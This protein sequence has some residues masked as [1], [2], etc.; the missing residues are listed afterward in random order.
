MPLT[1][2]T[3]PDARIRRVRV[4][5]RGAVQGVGFRPFVN[6]LAARLGL[7]GW[8][9]NDG[10]GVLLEVEGGGVSAFMAALESEA[11]PLARI[12]A[13]QAEDVSPTGEVGFVIRHSEQGG[14][15]T[16]IPPDAAVCDACLGELFDPS[17]RHYRYAFINCTHCGPRYT[18]TRALPYD[19]PQTSMAAFAMCADCAREY[20]DPL[21]RRFH[22]QPVACPACGP[23]LSMPIEDIVA[24]LKAGEIL[25][26]KGLGGFHIVCDARNE[27]AVSRLRERKN[28]EEKPLAVMVSN[29]VSAR[30]LAHIGYE[31][32]VLLTSLTRPII[33]LP[34]AE[35]HG[36]APS[37][38]PG[39][40]DV[41]VMLPYTPIHY[42][43]F[44]ETAGRPDGT[45]WLDDFQDLVLV[46]TSANP[47]GEPLVIGNDEA[48]G[49]LDGIADA[50][51]THDRDIVVRADDTV[52]RFLGG[53]PA[54]IRRARG[55]VPAPVKLPRA[56]PSG[57]AV[58]AHLK[59]TVCVVRG[60]E[61]FVSQ[62]VGDLDTPEALTFF[63]ETVEHLLSITDVSPEWV[64]HDLHPDFFATRY[65]EDYAQAHDLP[66]YAV[67]H[68]H[69]H[70]AS[71][72]AEVGLE[73]PALGLALDGFG[74]GEG[75]GTLNWGGE[76]LLVD[77]ADY[78]RLG[79]LGELL[80]PGGEAAFRAPWRIAAAV[81]HRHGRG[82]EIASRFAGF[83][84]AEMMGQ[85]LDRG[86]NVIPSTGCG[87]LF[88]AAAGLAGV[89]P[90]ASF[91]AQAPMKLEAL[92]TN[93]GVLD[94]AWTVT[95]GVLD[96]SGLLLA[97]SD[98][99]AE[100]AANAFHGTLIAALTDWA[101]GLAGA[102][103]VRDIALGGGCLLNRVLHDGLHGQLRERG[104]S[105]HSPRLV[106]PGDGG[107]SLGQAYVAIQR[108]RGA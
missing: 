15:T 37:I 21:D 31:E 80:L 34:K 91:E 99:D 53:R 7:S 106:P 8:V 65:A 60:D 75:E 101:A 4:R 76:A 6:G 96:L 27:S 55:Y 105:V 43:L 10:D 59:N 85:V 79:H 36:L 67:Q 22:A 90:L 78:Q 46:M 32:G 100:D 28:R 12:D 64:A 17:D 9:L 40:K 52:M 49:R 1:P 2:P 26:I 95:D 41:G 70:I 18:L 3:D 77:G 19:R 24:R 25:A 14:V 98:M 68:H 87:R 30:R 92:A 44:H 47:G 11:P 16:T 83:D 108:H 54:F 51:V 58:G 86:V 61:A 20:V 102:A 62:H 48:H 71:V 73:R 72:M 89:Q 107:L 63:G 33:V 66:A 93:P 5:V 56:Y 42:L 81:L 13:V 23:K 45:A 50:I 39:L 88:D 57:L 69:A 94:G 97:I 103:G 104:L 35:G 29:L 38:A 74:L 82:G 84:G